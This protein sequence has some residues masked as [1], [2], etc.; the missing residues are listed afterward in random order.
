MARYRTIAAIPAVGTD[1]MTD[2]AATRFVRGSMCRVR[3]NQSK[4]RQVLV[5]PHAASSYNRQDGKYRVRLYGEWIVVP[6]NAVSLCMRGLI[7]S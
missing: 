7:S 2:S 6:D 5:S 1:A 3:A 4:L